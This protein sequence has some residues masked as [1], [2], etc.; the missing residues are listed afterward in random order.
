VGILGPVAWGVDHDALNPKGR[1]RE[2]FAALFTGVLR[3]DT[4]R[5]YSVRVIRAER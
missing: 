4:P 3:C 1:G 2:T 5:S